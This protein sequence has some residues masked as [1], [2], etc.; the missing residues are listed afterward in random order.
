[1]IILSGNA[2]QIEEYEPDII[3]LTSLKGY[4]FEVPYSF[5]FDSSKV[6]IYFYDNL[7]HTVE[8]KADVKIEKRILRIL[9]NGEIGVVENYIKL[10]PDL[11]LCFEKTSYPSKFFYRKAQMW[12]G[13]Q[14]SKSKVLGHIIYNGTVNRMLFTPKS[15]E[16][17]GILFE[18]TTYLILQ[19]EMLSQ[20]YDE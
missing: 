5:Y 17:E 8:D 4:N 16:D 2:N 10:P 6:F 1:M 14:I 13:A 3:I 7:K 11:F 19:G 18:G 12:I 15:K 9:L 20:I